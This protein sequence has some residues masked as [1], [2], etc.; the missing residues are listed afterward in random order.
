MY[1]LS[2]VAYR[3]VSLRWK[4]LASS[5]SLDVAVIELEPK[6]IITVLLQQQSSSQL[7][8]PQRTDYRLAMQAH[9]L[10]APVIAPG[11]WP[12]ATTEEKQAELYKLKQQRWV[13]AGMESCISK[14]ILSAGV[15]MSTSFR[16]LVS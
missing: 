9:P 4:Q 8:G 12:G 11:C 1:E 7:S 5:A 13:A 3:L 10:I 14:G 16:V 15:G 2:V 6:A